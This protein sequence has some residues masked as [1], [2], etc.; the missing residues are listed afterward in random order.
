[1]KVKKRELNLLYGYIYNQRSR[2]EDDV[3]QLQTYIRYNRI[4]VIDCTE[5]ICAIERLNTFKQVTSDL[6]LL[7]NLRELKECEDVEK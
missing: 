6:M 5:L 7:L 3:R 2:Y 1:M 4:D